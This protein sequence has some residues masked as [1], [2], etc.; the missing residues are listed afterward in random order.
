M[1]AAGLERATA[2]ANDAGDTP[3]FTIITDTDSFD[4]CQ[5]LIFDALISSTNL[6]LATKLL[7][8]VL[9]ID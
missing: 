8:L 1:V 2:N 6:F 5:S 9:A 7:L 4:Y 3:Q